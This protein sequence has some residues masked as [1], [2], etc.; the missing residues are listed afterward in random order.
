M[1]RN[2]RFV[3]LDVHKDTIAIAVAEQGREGEVRTYGTI[4]SDLHAVERAIAKLRADGA[5]LHV[6]YEAGCSL[7]RIHVR[8]KTESPSSS[9]GQLV[10][11]IH[12]IRGEFGRHAATPEEARGNLML[13]PA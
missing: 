12:D 1:N 6:A 5:E 10:V 9:N 13:A 11:R 3:G 2:K 8:N 4:S 7:V